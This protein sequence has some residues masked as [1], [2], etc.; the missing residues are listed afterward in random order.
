M[1]ERASEQ[2][3]EGFEE[4]RVQV[5]EEFEQLRAGIEKLRAEEGPR[6]P[7]ARKRKSS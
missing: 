2:L 4:L 3:R 7:R 6:K 5:R 1:A